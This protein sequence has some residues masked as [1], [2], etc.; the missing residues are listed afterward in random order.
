MHAYSLDTME[1]HCHDGGVFFTPAFPI[2][3][4]ETFHSF[5]ATLPL[6]VMESGSDVPPQ[7][8]ST[9]AKQMEEIIDAFIEEQDIP[10]TEGVFVCIQYLVC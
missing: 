2:S 5:L 4:F 8:Y 1:H 6:P 9:P 10:V 7:K 3:A